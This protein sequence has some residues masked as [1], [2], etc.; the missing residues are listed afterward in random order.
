MTA[1]LATPDRLVAIVT[2][3]GS[4]VGREIALSL[5]KAGYAVAAIDIDAVSLAKLPNQQSAPL[6]GFAC[7]VSDA[8]AVAAT[9]ARVCEQ[10]GPP[11]LL[12]NA[13]GIA[14]GGALTSS[15]A[16]LARASM[17]VNYLGTVQWVEA[18]LPDMLAHGTGTIV[19]IASLA[20]LVPCHGMGVYA[21]SKAAVAMYTE[22]LSLEVARRGIR[23]VCVCPPAVNTPLLVRLLDQGAMP[24]AIRRFMKPLEPAAVAAAVMRAI[25]SRRTVVV[26]GTAAR[27]L[28][29]VNRWAPHVTQLFSSRYLVLPPQPIEKHK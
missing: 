10:L 3:S 18:V 16:S 14:A 25:K 1:R 7:D 19:N 17:Q 24:T 12:I 29:Q 9:H 26:L 23:V 2:G 11:R 27:V 22:V 28:W 13:A 21:A 20:A 15:M 5:V 6:I 4:G 8:G